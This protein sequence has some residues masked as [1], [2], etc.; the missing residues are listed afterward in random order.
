MYDINKLITQISIGRSDPESHLLDLEHWSPHV[1]Q[2][3]AQEEGIELS[4]A[5]WAVIFCLR[6]RFRLNGPARSARELSREMETEF[7]DDGGRR[8]LYELF[9]HGPIVQAC[10][11]AGLPL[12]PGTRDMSFGSV[13]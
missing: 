4:E 7:A 3:F 13:H 5:H 2:H 12:P 6:E 11:I 8:F 1:A 9:P 10:H